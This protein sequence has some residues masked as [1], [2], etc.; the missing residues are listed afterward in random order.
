MRAHRGENKWKK[1]DTCGTL[2]SSIAYR[3]WLLKDFLVLQ[4]IKH[5]TALSPVHNGVIHESAVSLQIE[6]A[7]GQHS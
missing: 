6:L 4:N 5:L 2:G 7:E 3:I 1:I